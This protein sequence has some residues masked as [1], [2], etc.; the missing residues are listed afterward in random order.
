[1][2]IIPKMKG[3]FRQSTRPPNEW[4]PCAIAIAVLIAYL[5]YNWELN[6]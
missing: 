1:M 2:Y 3:L 4:I 5:I 6:K